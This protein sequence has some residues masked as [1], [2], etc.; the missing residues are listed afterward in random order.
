MFL[1]SCSQRG[2]Q[3][4]YRARSVFLGLGIL[5]LSACTQSHTGA[6]IFENEYQQLEAGLTQNQV[7]ELLGAP[8]FTG[9]ETD[10]DWYYITTEWRRALFFPRKISERQLT[11]IEFDNNKQIKAFARSDISNV[12]PIKPR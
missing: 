9:Q 3:P 1:L 6:F 10:K 8:S 12:K 4:F 11:S 2:L 7:E 5:M